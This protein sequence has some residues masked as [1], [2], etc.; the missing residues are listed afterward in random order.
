MAN[1]ISGDESGA[2][3]LGSPPPAGTRRA[4]HTL[5]GRKNDGGEGEGNHLAD[6]KDCLQGNVCQPL[7]KTRIIPVICSER[8]RSFFPIEL[9]FWLK[10]GWC[11]QG[12]CQG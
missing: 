10:G 1:G 8:Q 4:L 2:H 7:Y 9:Q 5:R 6:Y 11:G 3:G 12:E